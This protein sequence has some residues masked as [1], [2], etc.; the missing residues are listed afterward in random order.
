MAGG[1]ATENT[2]YDHAA[3]AL[4]MDRLN[5]RRSPCPPARAVLISATGRVLGVYHLH[6][7][8]EIQD[9]EPEDWRAFW[10]Q[11]LLVNGPIVVIGY[12]GELLGMD[13]IRIQAA[14]EALGV[15]VYFEQVG[16][17]GG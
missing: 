12:Q 17:V 13:Q 3:R 5:C 16:R 7:T 4:T 6:R 8:K 1:G 14:A 9:L 10:R 2:I 11:V 15:R